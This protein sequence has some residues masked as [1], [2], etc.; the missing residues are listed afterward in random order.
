MIIRA[1]KMEQKL[2][3]HEEELEPT[4]DVETSS[5]MEP[6][7][8][9]VCKL[10][11]AGTS[12]PNYWQAQNL[13]SALH[14]QFEE[15]RG[16]G[17]VKAMRGRFFILAHYYGRTIGILRQALASGNEP[18]INAALRN[19]VT[20]H[21]PLHHMH[22]VAPTRVPFAIT[23]DRKTRRTL[24][25]DL[26]IQVLQESP[27]PL[28]IEAITSRV[29]DLHFMVNAKSDIINRYLDDLIAKG[30]VHRVEDGFARTKRTYSSINIDQASLQALLGE[31]LYQEFEK[32]S[33]PGLSNIV[34]RKESFR[35]F[36]QRFAHCGS[37]MA[38]MFIAASIELLAIPRIQVIIQWKHSDLIN[39]L[40][41]RPYQHDAYAIFRGYGYQG[42]VIESPS[43][44]GKTMIGMMC[45]QDWLRGLSPGE[46]ILILVPTVNY[47]QQWVGEL[48]YKPIGLQVS[49]D[50]IFT[51]TPAELEA[52][53]KR[54]GA[55]PAIL[56]TTYT[57][58]A[59]LGSPAGKGGFDTISVERFLQ[60]NN[61]QYVI[62][63][64]VHKVVED[65]KSVSAQVTLLLTEWLR[66]GSLRGLIGFS[67]TAAAFRDRFENLGL[68]LAYTMPA[69]DLI[70]YG[71]VAPFAEYGVPFTH[72][73]REKRVIE[74]LKEYKSYIIEYVGLLGSDKLRKMFTDIPFEKRI[75]IGRDFLGLYSS[76]KDRDIA[77]EK[78]YD[79]WEHRGK[80]TLNHLP[81]I[82][83]IQIAGNFSDIALFESTLT[84]SPAEEKQK[85]GILFQEILLKFEK[86]RDELKELIHFPDITS[87]LNANNFGL[88]LNAETIP[89]M[90]VQATNRS[91]FMGQVKDE[92]APS[93]VGLYNIL[94]S[95][96]FRLG[97]G[98]VDSIK[99]I[100]DAELSARKVTGVI[101]FD[102]AKKIRWESETAVPGYSGVGGLFAQLLG[103]KRFTP[104]A[105]ISSEIYLPWTEKDF[106][107][108]KVADHIRQK[109]MF[110]ELG[111]AFFSLV[112]Q[113]TG[114]SEEQLS[115]LEVTFQD[116]LKDYIQNL[117]NVGA[118]RPGEFNRLVIKKFRKVVKKAKLGRP[119]EKLRDRLSL[120]HN[121][122][123]R[124]IDNFFDYALISS[125][126][127]EA[128]TG[129]LRQ[130]GGTHQKFFAVKMA[131]GE[132]KQLMYDLIARIV[133]S[134]DLPVNVVIVSSWARTGWNV[135]SP[136]ILIDAT[137]T[138]NITAWQQLRGRAMRALTTWNR[139]CYELVMVLLGSHLRGIE[140]AADKLPPDVFAL[141]ELQ[142]RH[143]VTDTLNEK[144]IQLILEAHKTAHSLM[145]DQT[146]TD[147]SLI[148]KI[149]KGKLD[150][151]K[152]DEKEMLAAEL[153][154]SRNKVTH[155]YELVKAYGSSSQ[156]RLDRTSKTWHRSEAIAS[157]HLREYS[158]SPISGQYS[159]GESHAPL[160]FVHD[161]QKNVPS[162]FRDFLAK[163]LRGGDPLIVN[164]W[165]RAVLSRT[166]GA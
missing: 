17:D 38:E 159:R 111:K 134:E 120:K 43:G 48:C 77:L 121:H 53:R 46:S 49:P 83:M 94:R 82:T 143:E 137:A 126:F 57:A 25:E 146:Q 152:E 140:E 24:V 119:G 55:S 72:S 10:P 16:K 114:L 5:M 145:K 63:D 157:K 28:L 2:D 13:A 32:G 142:E 105:A 20:L 153:M 64:E 33:F 35:K 41:P 148:N 87:K 133:D 45:I 67:G 54:T 60:G 23:L 68:Q 139:D 130:T 144:Q 101:I 116:L 102:T 107:P 26:I 104:M 166:G 81:I 93:I 136:N 110:L 18:L 3:D 80:F 106:L 154:I 59:Q 74:L 92:L 150:K 123:R 70:A 69:A 85:K 73:D 50:I 27:E 163:E 129:E 165:I 9:L 86:I 151:F 147:G 52:E 135:I 22:E 14:Q 164:G 131:G 79:V 76:R 58:L 12:P 118:T 99:S 66:D 47:E 95:F 91:V 90:S 125:H 117:S 89:Q 109:I 56:I 1:V 98:R 4:L 65:L 122:I 71:F 96:Y 11:T 156:V 36:F 113:K 30:H 127:L 44:S 162:L 39:S 160:Y 84:D 29:N 62:L 124:W 42:Q 34:T 21:Q 7:S 115:S 149:M 88:F 141:E 31:K 61:I 19:L 161:P 112:T 103:D 51:G 40:I 100:V 8:A 138:R 132:R 128:K 155:I 15:L 37:E 108:S 158:I 6:I 97:E 78:R 75:V